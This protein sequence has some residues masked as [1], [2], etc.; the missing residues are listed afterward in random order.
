MHPKLFSFFM[1]CML[2]EIIDPRLPRG[3][4]IRDPA[5]ITE[6]Q[7]RIKKKSKQ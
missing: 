3:L 1:D 5:K 2:P 6:A 7:Y 4:Q